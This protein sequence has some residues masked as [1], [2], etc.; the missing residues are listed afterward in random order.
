MFSKKHFTKFILLFAVGLVAACGSALYIPSETEVTSKANLEELNE[1]RA[2]YINKC[3]GCHT[4]VLPE[5]YS[6]KDWNTWVDK[7][8]VK[9]KITSSEKEK[10]LKYV[11]R[12]K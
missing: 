5:K 3:G 2:I 6:S 7:M 12:G 10:I 9:A 4:L 8:E 11:T 1:G